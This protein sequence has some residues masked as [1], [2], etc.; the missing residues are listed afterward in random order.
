LTYDEFGGFY[1]HVPPKPAVSPDRNTAARLAHQRLVHGD[2][3]PRWTDLRFYI[4]RL[5]SSLD[6]GL[7]LLEEELRL[8]YCR[9]LHRHPETHRDAIQTTKLDK[10][11]AAQMDMTEFF[12]FRQR[13]MGDAAN[14]AHPA[15]TAPC[16]L[17]HLP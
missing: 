15:V 6:G 16:Y 8:A 3:K 13:A 4:Y 11:D 14:Y 17:D 5:S 1:D 2:A 10:R 7:S 12:D 9:R